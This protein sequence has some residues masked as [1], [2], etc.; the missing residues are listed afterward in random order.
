MSLTAHAVLSKLMADPVTTFGETPLYVEMGATDATGAAFQ[1]AFVSHNDTVFFQPVDVC[2][3]KTETRLIGTFVPAHR[4]IND[5]QMWVL[6][7]P[8]PV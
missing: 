7:H 4:S 2:R 3:T 1:A 5:P 8:E 6:I